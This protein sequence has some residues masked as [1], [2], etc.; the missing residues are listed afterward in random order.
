MRRPWP[1][2]GFGAREKKMLKLSL[3]TLLRRMWEGGGVEDT[4]I[5]FITPAVDGGK[6]VNGHHHLPT[7]SLIASRKAVPVHVG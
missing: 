6:E 4:C 3:C 1:E 5:F 2:M 7:A